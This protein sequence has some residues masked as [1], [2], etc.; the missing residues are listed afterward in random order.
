M[1]GMVAALFVAIGLAGHFGNGFEWRVDERTM[2]I[3]RAETDIA[4]A[5]CHF[6]LNLPGDFVL[7]HPQQQC[8]SSSDGAADVMLIGDS[9]MRSIADGVRS[10]LA[11]EGIENYFISHTSCLPLF[12]FKTFDAAITYDCK[13]FL[14]G[15]F[16]W[17]KLTGVSTVVLAARFPLYLYGTPYDNGEGGIET[18]GQSWVDVLDRTL[19]ESNNDERRARVLSAYEQRIRELAEDFNVVLIYPVPEAGWNVPGYAFKVAFFNN[20]NATVT[21]SFDSY[22]D[23]A[24]EV[25]ALFDR[26]V[27]EVPNVYGARVHEVLCN[28]ATDR[29]MNA[30]ANGVYYYDDDHLSNAGAR[31]VAPIIVKAIRA[32]LA[33]EG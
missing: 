5:A 25:N 8:L 14:D 30:D 11:R 21:T 6:D 27:T 7:K 20:G 19:S 26:L 32:A 4:Q 1:S 18:A 10:A 9:H 31:L 12:G 28:E 24:S 2:R 22:K 13:E 23:R 3:A 17:A 33:N 15:A 29:C 16:A